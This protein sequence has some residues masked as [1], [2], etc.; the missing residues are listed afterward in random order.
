M[1]LSAPATRLRGLAFLLLACVS[2][3]AGRASAL[4][5][6]DLDCT[7]GSCQSFVAGGL[8][9]DNFNVIIS[10]D[11]NPSLLA[12]EVTVLGD[13]FRLTGPIAAS[14]GQFGDI[15]LS[16]DVTSN[17]AGVGIP[18]AALA[19]M[20]V[21]AGG[22]QTF[23]S[24]TDDFFTDGPDP[25]ADLFVGVSAG[26]VSILSDSTA[27]NPAPEKLHVIKDIIVIGI[28]GSTA[29]EF[30]DQTHPTP[31][32]AASGMLGLGLLGLWRFG[33]RRSS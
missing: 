31:A 30:I 17:T 2:L 5:L 6:D 26:G 4:T 9:F 10:G 29:I 12:Y 8:T 21:A 19:F 7:V 33:R 1:H 32:P 3:F 24:V 15:V 25:I 22:P 13:G 28:N 20:A 18:G 23:A 16:Y 11:L 27:F 14:A